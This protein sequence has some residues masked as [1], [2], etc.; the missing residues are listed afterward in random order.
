MR[1]NCLSQFQEHWNCLE[2]NNQVRCAHYPSCSQCPDDWTQEYYMCR[3][4]E[5]TL[6]ACMF[7]K[8]VRAASKFLTI[9]HATLVP[10]LAGS[11]ED[12]SWNPS[13]QKTN[14]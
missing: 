7:E 12:H 11:H 14:T 5:R 4:P 2:Q 9:A 6:N 8:L 13:G 1:E 3:K 10:F